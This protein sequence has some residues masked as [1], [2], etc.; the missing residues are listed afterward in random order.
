MINLAE[1]LKQVRFVAIAGHVRPDGDATGSCLGL[2]HYLKKNYPE[3]DVRVYLENTPQAY[4]KV[5]GIDEVF[6][7]VG[8]NEA[9]DVFFCLDCADE[10]R[11]GGFAELKKRAK[12]V[13][14]IDH[15]VSNG[16]FADVNYIV[17][18]ASSTSELVFRLLDEE[19]MPVETAENLYMGLVHDTGVFRHS[20]TSPETME[21]AAT[22]MRKGIDAAG[23]INHTFYDKTYHQNQ[24]LGRALLESILL[25]DK[26]VI[27]SAIRQK[28][29][30]FY[31]VGPSDL[32]GIV[33]VL[34]STADTE[35]AI[36]LYEVSPQTFKV[37][38]RSREF[39]DVST[40]AA[41]FGGGGH[42]RAAG[43][44]MQGS[45]YDVVNNITLHIEKQLRQER[46]SD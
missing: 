35:V 37:S 24:I 12:R 15:H 2:Y 41:Y 13:I 21:I 20:C 25:M 28:E 5:P 19:K 10:K 29:M 45:I 3:T 33:Q 17:P 16:G 8:E 42:I 4:S 27:F 40:I 39:V 36:F 14:C 26:K 32:D 9:P 1:E 23:I 18:D 43:C 22:L 31:G 11:L 34:M 44:T 7:E 46:D 6:H 38:L 30:D